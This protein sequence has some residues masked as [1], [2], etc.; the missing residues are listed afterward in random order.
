MELVGDEEEVARRQ[1]GGGRM[2]APHLR[3][4]MVMGKTATSRRRRVERPTEEARPEESGR[5]R[6]A[7]QGAERRRHGR[8][9]GWRSRRRRAAGGWL[10]RTAARDFSAA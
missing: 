6:R 9:S 1:W 7:G 3:T 2:L 4:T 8:R 5:G 10:G